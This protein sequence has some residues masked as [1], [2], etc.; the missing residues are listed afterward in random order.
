MMIIIV[1]INE[2]F[3]ICTVKTEEGGNMY[4]WTI[5]II[6][7]PASEAT[8]VLII[9]PT[10]VFP[11]LLVKEEQKRDKLGILNAQFIWAL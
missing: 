6:Y 8:A 9:Q 2:I 11:G 10:L 3:Y 7:V 1:I 4:I 5:F